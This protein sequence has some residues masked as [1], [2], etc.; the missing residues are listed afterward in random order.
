MR[1]GLEDQQIEEAILEYLR[2]RKFDATAEC[3]HSENKNE[4]VLGKGTLGQQ[5]PDH[6]R[7]RVFHENLVPNYDFT[8]QLPGSV[9]EVF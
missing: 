4:R 2:W 8:P 9:A 7:V 6:Q 3:L 5:S 1:T